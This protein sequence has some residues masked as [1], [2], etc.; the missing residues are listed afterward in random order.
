M[1]VKSCIFVFFCV[2]IVLIV[3]PNIDLA[4]YPANIFFPDTKNYRIFSATIVVLFGHR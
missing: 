3:A 2:C 1:F 4:G